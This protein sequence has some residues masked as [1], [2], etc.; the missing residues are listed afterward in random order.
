MPVSSTPPPLRPGAWLAVGLAVL[1]ACG[2][3]SGDLALAE[4]WA[5]LAPEDDPV[6]GR[7]FDLP[8]CST[9]ALAVEAGAI[10]L[11]TDTCSWITVAAESR[12]NVRA[13]DP[14]ELFLFHSALTAPEPATSVLEI[15]LG[16]EIAW[17]ERLA[18]PGTTNFFE[19]TIESPTALSRGGL[20]YLHVHNHGA[21][22]YTLGHLRIP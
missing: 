14:I 19:T 17:E 13:G 9:L 5:L 16:D 4:D 7:P 1:S 18:I 3:D 8:P 6:P 12:V 2:P 21:N 15:R 11:A 20:V 10:E 22:T